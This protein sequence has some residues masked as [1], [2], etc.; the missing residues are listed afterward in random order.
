MKC[1]KVFDKGIKDEENRA[2]KNK[3]YLDEFVP[4]EIV[5]KHLL[6]DFKWRPW[7]RQG[8]SKCISNFLI[9]KSHLFNAFCSHRCRRR[10][11][12]D[13][14]PSAPFRHLPDRVNFLLLTAA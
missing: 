6:R 1:D 5:Y 13:I 7:C 3:S 10:C 11:L 4:R 8:E 12:P 14:V 2:F 9:V